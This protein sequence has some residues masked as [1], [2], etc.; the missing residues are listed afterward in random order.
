MIQQSI[1]SLQSNRGGTIPIAIDAVP[2]EEPKPIVLILHGFKGFATWGFFPW[3]AEQIARSGMIAV[4][5]NFSHNGVEKFGSEFTRLDL[6]EENTMGREIDETLQVIEALAE[7]ALLPDNVRSS[8]SIGLLGH[9]RGGGIALL[10]SSREEK[11]DA[12]VTWAAVSTFDRFSRHQLQ[13]WR[14]SGRLEVKN[15]R[16]GQTMHLGSKML[17]EL[18]Q[19]RENLDICSAV[20]KLRR[21]LLLVHGEVDLSVTVENAEALHGAADPGLTTLLLVSRTGHTF[22][23]GHP[24]EGAS[25]ALNEVLSQSLAFLDRHLHRSPR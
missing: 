15:S 20:Q 18:E 2:A 17:E 22:G 24:F 21:P 5:V 14:E 23:V 7:G 25:D 13:R 8:G 10:A 11:V 19:N 12:I 16:T 3:L 6:F 9:S 4:R 1:T